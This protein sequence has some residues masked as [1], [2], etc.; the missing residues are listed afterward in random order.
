MKEWSSRG[1][2]QREAS[3]L[4]RSHDLSPQ[5]SGGWARG[6]WSET[7]GGLRYL[8]QRSFDWLEKRVIDPRIEGPF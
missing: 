8:T 4:L 5:T 2:S 1:L 7:R 3:E 6:G